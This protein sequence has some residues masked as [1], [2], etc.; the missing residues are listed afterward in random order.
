[1]CEE[2]GKDGY[3][4]IIHS[5]ELEASGLDEVFKLER[6]EEKKVKD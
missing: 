2:P 5:E 1:M 4:C 3:F 6:K